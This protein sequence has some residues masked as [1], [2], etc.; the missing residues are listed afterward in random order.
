MTTKIE[1][2][3]NSTLALYNYQK[4]ETVKSTTF[5]SVLI[6]LFDFYICTSCSTEKHVNFVDSRINHRL[7]RC[8]T[9]ILN[10]KFSVTYVLLLETHMICVWFTKNDVH[11]HA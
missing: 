7:I 8:F 1:R 6:F 5:F 4:Q 2:F 9:D 3:A 11:E 10:V